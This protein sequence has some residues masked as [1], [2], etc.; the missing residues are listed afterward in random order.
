MH[1]GEKEKSIRNTNTLA[2]F[3][4]EF[5][6]PKNPR[7]RFR[8]LTLLLGL[9]AVFWIGARVHAADATP[10]TAAVGQTDGSSDSTMNYWD[11]YKKGGPFMY[12][13]TAC[14]VLAIGVIIERFI[15]LRRR[16]VMPPGFMPGLKSVWRDPRN[17]RD[18]AIAYCT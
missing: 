18:A 12:P 1:T 6:K 2:F 3:A 15:A 10:T 13:L 14:S 7:I 9:A 5:M 4:D 8:L 16:V 17:D 11:L